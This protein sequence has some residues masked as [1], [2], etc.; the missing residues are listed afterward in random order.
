MAR[1]P[2]KDGPRLLKIEIVVNQIEK[3]A[4]EARA[5]EAGVPPAV[6]LRQLGL[7]VIIPMETNYHRDDN[8][9][10]GVI[11]PMVTQELPSGSKCKPLPPKGV[12]AEHN[13]AGREGLSFS[14]E[15]L[16]SSSPEEKKVSGSEELFKQFWSVVKRKVGRGRAQGMVQ[17]SK[18]GR[19]GSHQRSDRR[20]LRKSHGQHIP[21][22]SSHLAER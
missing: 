14:S 20:I 18:E 5:K 21:Q 17:G 16:F 12:A 7:G 13:L 6:F 11:I 2:S 3:D 10:I 8:S 19:P 15:S 4:I 1:P 9:K 22:A